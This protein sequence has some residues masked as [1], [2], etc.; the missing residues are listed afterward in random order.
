MADEKPL[1]WQETPLRKMSALAQP[2]KVFGMGDPLATK[3]FGKIDNAFLDAYEPITTPVYKPGL[4]NG[5]VFGSYDD[6]VEKGWV[7]PKMARPQMARGGAVK[8]YAKGGTV[9]GGGCET[10][11]K[12]KGRFV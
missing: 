6:L 4:S 2:A 11:G 3:L 12:T 9:R 7:K 1:S 10:R 5:P 8:K